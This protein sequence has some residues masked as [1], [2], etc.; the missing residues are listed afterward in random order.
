MPFVVLHIL[1][2]KQT[3]IIDTKKYLKKPKNPYERISL[4]EEI[5]RNSSSRR[6]VTSAYRDVFSFE[7]TNEIK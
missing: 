2:I 6:R 5:L 4:K 3:L 7:I 1:K